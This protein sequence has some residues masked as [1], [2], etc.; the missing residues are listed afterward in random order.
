INQPAEQRD[1]RQFP[2]DRQQH[3]KKGRRVQRV[4]IFVIAGATIDRPGLG[5]ALPMGGDIIG[6]HSSPPCAIGKGGEL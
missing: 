6:V 1:D 3:V 4:A 2:D 5:I